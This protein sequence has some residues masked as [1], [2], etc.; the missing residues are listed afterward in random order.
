M[1]D[2]QDKEKLKLTFLKMIKITLKLF[3]PLSFD[4]QL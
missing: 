2:Y 3:I 4:P 1:F